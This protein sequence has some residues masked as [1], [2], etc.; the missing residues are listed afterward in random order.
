MATLEQLAEGI[1]RAHAA[2]DAASVRKLGAAYRAMQSSRVADM[3]PAGAKPGSR[4]YADWA[5]TQARAGK[6]LRQVSEAPEFEAPKPTGLMDKAFTAAGSFIEGVPLVG[7]TAIDLAKTARAG[8]Q[9]MTREEADQEFQALKEANP[10]TAGVGNVAGSIAGLAPLGAT[11]LGGRLLGMTGNIGSRMLYGAGSGAAISGAD[12]LTRGGSLEDAK[13]SALTGGAFGLAFPVAGAAFRKVVSPAAK[14]ATDTAADLLRREGVEL[15][16]GQATGRKGLRAFEG[17][18]GG[19]AASDLVERQGRQFTAAALRRAGVDADVASPEVIDNAFT[20]IGGQFDG[21]ISRNAI[22]PDN[23]LLVRDL[24]AV[25]RQFEGSTGPSTRPPVIE[26][27]LNDIY[28]AGA[29]GPISGAWYKAQRTALGNL[30][31]SSNPELA[32]AA[33]GIMSALDSAME[34][35]LSR[36][37]SPDV[38]AWREARRLYKN[39]LVIEDAVTRGGAAADGVITPQALRD[40]AIQQN[41]RA[42]ARGRN[43][44]TRLAN[45]GVAKMKPLPEG[46]TS[47]MPV[48]ASLGA[49]LGAGLGGIPGAVIGGITGAAVPFAAGRG[50]LSRAGRAYL[51]NRVAAGGRPLPALPPAVLSLE[52]TREREPVEIEVRGGAL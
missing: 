48:G 40:A 24:P 47:I 33:R 22:R 15:T 17:K 28:G 12:T 49:S 37:G 46:S 42:F 21:L 41:K 50:M 18:I 3:P 31:K 35:T 51:G 10:I 7:S 8:I 25:W 45:A 38:G 2:G 26:R 39:M 34:R 36:A 30:T 9:G 1:K 27:I 23:M 11:A 32:E 44:F 29:A 20:N 4:E 13:N 14:T 5:M 19:G 43:E 16:A 6:K 52:R